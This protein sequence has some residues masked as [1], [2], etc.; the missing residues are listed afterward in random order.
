MGLLEDENTLVYRL[1]TKPI[2]DI[3]GTFQEASSIILVDSADYS[4]SRPRE[5]RYSATYGVHD[6]KKGSVKQ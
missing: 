4:P 1:M 3:E 2:R 5:I 6:T